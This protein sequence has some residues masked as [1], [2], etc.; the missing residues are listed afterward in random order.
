MLAPV[1]NAKRMTNDKW[2]V[3]VPLFDATLG[4]LQ[5]FCTSLLRSFE[6]LI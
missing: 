6:Q 4:S 5:W 1:K 3:K 2:L